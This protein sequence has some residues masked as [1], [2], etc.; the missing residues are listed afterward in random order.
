ML[1]LRLATSN[2]G[3]QIVSEWNTGNGNW[4]VPASWSGNDVPDNGGG[5]IYNVQIGNR[6]VANNAE[7]E[8]VPEDGTSDTINALTIT[9]GADLSLNGQQLNVTHANPRRGRRQSAGHG[10][11]CDRGA[12][13]R[14]RQATSFSTAALCLCSSAQ[15]STSAA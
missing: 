10:A 14:Y 15:L 1:L 2:L 7:V 8:F 5:N 12:R 4:N 11:A 13:R 3:A 6:P 9:N